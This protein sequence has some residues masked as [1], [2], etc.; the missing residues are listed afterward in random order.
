MMRVSK[1]ATG[2]DQTWCHPDGDDGER[3]KDEAEIPTNLAPAI[4]VPGSRHQSLTGESVAGDAREI[5]TLD[6]NVL[7][8]RKRTI[9][10]GRGAR[11]TY[12]LT[13]VLVA[14][15]ETQPEVA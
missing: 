8:L 5:I 9:S 10:V 13:T 2:L 15:S 6:G 3:S 4:E 1:W 7:F 14:P 12:A 11:P